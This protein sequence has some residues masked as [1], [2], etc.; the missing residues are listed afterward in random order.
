MKSSKDR[1]KHPGTQKFTAIML[2]P[3]NTVLI[4]T[5]INHLS[6]HGG[7]RV[8]SRILHHGGLGG[9]CWRFLRK[10]TGLTVSDIKPPMRSLTIA[11]LRRQTAT[12]G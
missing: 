5:I 11:I 10:V 2:T 9:N 8:S 12:I 6:V 7:G 4:I 3:D 1:K